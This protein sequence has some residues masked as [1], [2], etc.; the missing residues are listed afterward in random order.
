MPTEME[1]L[2]I[3]AKAKRQSS[4]Q[5][6]RKDTRRDISRSTDT[7]TPHQKSGSPDK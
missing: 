1:N 5:I 3:A 6:R 2:A 7:A 4:P